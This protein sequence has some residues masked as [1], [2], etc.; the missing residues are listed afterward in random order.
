MRKTLSSPSLLP[1]SYSTPWGRGTNLHE[2]SMDKN[3]VKNWKLFYLLSS[4]KRVSRRPVD[5]KL[6]MKPSC[7]HCPKL[8]QAIITSK[9]VQ[10][11]EC[12]YSCEEA[13]LSTCVIFLIDSLSSSFLSLYSLMGPES[14]LELRAQTQG[15]RHDKL[16]HKIPILMC[17]KATSC[18]F[19]EPTKRWECA[20]QLF[21]EKH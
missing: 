17:L 7:P 12:K 20:E 4:P 6:L 5:I 19:L 21:L 9:Q 16:Y 10:L 8:L 2:V 13:L 14:Y 15:R 1:T 3:I 11:V 18:Q